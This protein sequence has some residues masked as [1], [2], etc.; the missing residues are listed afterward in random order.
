[1]KKTVRNI[2]LGCSFFA[3][4]F[5]AQAQESAPLA[6]HPEMPQLLWQIATDY[7]REWLLKDPHSSY[8]PWDHQSVG[9]IDVKAQKVTPLFRIPSSGITYA[10]GG[11]QWFFSPRTEKMKDE[12]GHPFVVLWQFD[13]K[14]AKLIAHEV[15]VPEEWPITLMEWQTVAPP[16]VSKYNPGVVA[17][18]EGCFVWYTGVPV[19]WWD[20][21]A[22][23]KVPPGRYRTN[24]ENKGKT[25]WGNPCMLAKSWPIVDGDLRYHDRWCDGQRGYPSFYGF[26]L[27]AQKKALRCWSWAWDI[28]DGTPKNDCLFVD[29]PIKSPDS[30]IRILEKNKEREPWLSVSGSP[31]NGPLVLSL[32]IRTSPPSN[33]PPE[34]KKWNKIPPVFYRDSSAKNWTELPLP[35]EIP[36]GDVLRFWHTVAEGEVILGKAK[37]PADPAMYWLYRPQTKTYFKISSVPPHSTLLRIFKD[38]ILFLE[39]KEQALTLRKYDGTSRLVAQFPHHDH[40][41]VQDGP[42]NAVELTKEHVLSEVPQ[43]LLHKIIWLGNDRDTSKPIPVPTVPP[44]SSTP[45]TNPASRSTPSSFR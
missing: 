28:W 7:D 4:S 35:S 18:E 37:S 10:C 5:A 6:S 43:H 33:D 17:E 29:V 40:I 15:M 24:L 13:L 41:F 14:N 34:R 20:K 12:N 1:M 2:L 11:S 45:N 44:T 3:S 9:V 39:D 32:V 42:P 23:K 8:T 27:D 26:G 25:P 38:G 19:P 22:E 31:Q 21:E 16:E 36:E 30:L